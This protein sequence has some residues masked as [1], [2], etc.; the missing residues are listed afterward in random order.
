MVQVDSRAV[1]FADVLRRTFDIGARGMSHS[2]AED[3]MALDF[4]ERD[5]ER[6]AEL[7]EK[8]NEGLLTESEEAEIEAYNNVADLLALWQSRARQVLQQPI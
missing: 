3:V 2:L 6:A 8:A 5:A 7:S 1:V 4:S